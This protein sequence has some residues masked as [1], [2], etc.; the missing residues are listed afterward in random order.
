MNKIVEN[1]GKAL[2]AAVS[3]ASGQYFTSWDSLINKFIGDIKEYGATTDEQ[4]ETFL[5]EYC[6]IEYEIKG[7]LKNG[8]SILLQQ[9]HNL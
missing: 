7:E 6:G 9:M 5:K 8:Q 2:D 1:A 4:A 3:M